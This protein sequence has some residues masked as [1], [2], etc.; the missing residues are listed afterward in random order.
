VAELRRAPADGSL[1]A[2]QLQCGPADD[3]VNS[4]NRC[5]P[6]N[7]LFIFAA[8]AIVAAGPA[9]ADG[10]AANGEKIF[11]KCAACHMVGPDAKIKVGPVLNNL[12]GRTAGTNEEYSGKYSKD[13]IKAGEDGLVWTEQ[14]LDVYLTKPKDTVKKTK[15]AFAGLKKE[16]DRQDV[17]AYL[18]QFSPDYKPSE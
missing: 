4:T 1:R 5:Y 8:L 2:I 18:K 3:P 14:T 11:K 16:E 7:K 13:M 9:L 12:L 17:I 10:D 15:M 6:M